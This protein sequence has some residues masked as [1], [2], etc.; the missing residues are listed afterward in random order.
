[1]RQRR[2]RS[3]ALAAVTVVGALALAVPGAGATLAAEARRI[4]G[5]DRYATARAVAEATFDE[6]PTVILANGRSYADALSANYLSGG[7]GAPLL[8]TEAT[9]LPAG[10]LD[11]LAEL[12]AVRVVIVGGAS[13]VSED[14]VAALREGGFEVGRTSG[15]DRYETARRV[16][17]T[18]ARSSIGSV[19]GGRAAIVATGEGFAD[20]L[21]VAPISS[22]RGV[23]IL[24][25][26][27][28]TLHEA[29]RAALAELQIQRVLVVGGAAAVNDEVVREIE[30]T[31]IR[32]RRLAGA[33]RQETAVAVGTF[34]AESL[35]FAMDRA[36]VARGD[37][38]ADALAA[39]TRGGRLRAPIVLV[40]GPDD[41]GDVARAFLR[42]HVDSLVAVEVMGGER[43]LARPVVDDALQA[44]R[45]A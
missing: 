16:A 29:T 14:V 24:L 4:A 41:L 2:V 10:T 21:T 35:E 17:Q 30:A 28:R 9:E 38:F 13:A 43:V 33:T 22:A 37:Q 42:A 36:L 7:L 39:G 34:A 18:F 6:A 31:G 25:T 19:D 8:L 40:Q 20:A 26:T 5:P 44:A 1:M 15:G 27:P 23:P 32:V 45:G 11:T 3:A 12:R